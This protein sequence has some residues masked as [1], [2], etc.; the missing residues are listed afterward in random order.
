MKNDSRRL[1]LELHQSLVILFI[2]PRLADPWVINHMLVKH[3]VNFPP[4]YPKDDEQLRSARDG[5]E[6]SA[7]LVMTPFERMWT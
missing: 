2:G 6:V 1:H 3:R 4:L 7:L 5:Y